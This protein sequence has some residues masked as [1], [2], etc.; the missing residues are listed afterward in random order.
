[1]HMAVSLL[2][3]VR[4]GENKKRKKKGTTRAFGKSFCVRVFVYFDVIDL[5]GE[6][7]QPFTVS[8]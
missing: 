8:K 1:M 7:Q 5:V 2:Y 3:H 4:K 6:F